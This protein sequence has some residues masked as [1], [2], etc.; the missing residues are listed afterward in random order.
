MNENIIKFLEKQTCATICCVD[1]IGKPYCFSCFYAFNA[2]EGLI[3]FKSSAE[4]YH[5]VLMKKN[6]FIAGTVLPDKLKVLVVKGVQFEGDV[7]DT[8]H[9]LMKQASAYYHK[10]HPMALAMTGEIWI[11]QIKSIKMT[12]STMGFRKKI[13]WSRDEKVGIMV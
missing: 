7:A 5:S 4:S 6:P 2:E 3:Y 10:K 9:P 1:E 12:D 11:I 8:D 13:S